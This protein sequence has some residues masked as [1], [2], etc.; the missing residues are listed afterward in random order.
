MRAHRS[1]PHTDDVAVA[2]KHRGFAITNLIMVQ[3]RGTRDN[4]QLIAIDIDLGQLVGLDRVFDRQ[5]MEVV[6]CL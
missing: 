6:G 4:K 1:M 2:D 5:R 3:M